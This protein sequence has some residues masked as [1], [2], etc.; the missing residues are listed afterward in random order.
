MHQVTHDHTVVNELVERGLLD[1]EQAATHPLRNLITNSV[2]GDER[3]L[4]AE[5][6]KIA[7]EP[8]DVI[9]LCSDGLTEMLDDDDIARTLVG[10]GD[11]QEACDRLVV[12]ANEAGGVDNITTIVAQFAP[13]S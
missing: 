6:H 8:N 10:S 11:P 5:V 2:G 7:I 4:R 13:L 12:A 1:A 3:G 9:V